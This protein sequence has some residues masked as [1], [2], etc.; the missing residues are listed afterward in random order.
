MLKR[1]CTKCGK[2]ETVKADKINYTDV[3][4]SVHYSC[5]CG[6]TFVTVYE[7]VATFGTK[8]LKE[9]V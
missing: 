5:E 8:R 7:E 9:S 3:G 2:I 6:A 1:V 4:M